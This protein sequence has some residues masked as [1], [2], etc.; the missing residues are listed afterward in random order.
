MHN[1]Q[2]LVNVSSRNRKYFNAMIKVLH[3]NDS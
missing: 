2:T 1:F 3:W